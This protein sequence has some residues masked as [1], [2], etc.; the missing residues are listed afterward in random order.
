MIVKKFKNGNYNVKME[1]DDFNQESTLVNLLWALGDHDCQLF[2][3]EYCLGNAVG[4]AVD[5]YD[6]YTDKLVRIP[7]FVL[8]ELE[9]GKTVK[10]YARKLDEFNREEYKHLAAL[11]EI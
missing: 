10:L 3:D 6:C 7:Y 9:T 8:D 11:E 1:K 5:L 2:G 4:M